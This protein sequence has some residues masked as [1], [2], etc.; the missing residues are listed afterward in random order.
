MC[1][2]GQQDSQA[3]SM[4]PDYKQLLPNELYIWEA[5]GIYTYHFVALDIYYI[6]SVAAADI[7]PY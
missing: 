4:S 7:S 5:A 6:S 3:L 2:R 1:G